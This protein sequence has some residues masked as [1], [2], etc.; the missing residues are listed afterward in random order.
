MGP[1][2]SILV[3]TSL[4]N[5]RILLRQSDSGMLQILIKQMRCAFALVFCLISCRITASSIHVETGWVVA[6]V[7]ALKVL[8]VLQV[9]LV[10]CTA[11]VRQIPQERHPLVLKLRTDKLVSVDTPC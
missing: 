7:D 9:S 1:L 2:S 3:I 4:H 5:L 11:L 8:Q 6:D 10:V